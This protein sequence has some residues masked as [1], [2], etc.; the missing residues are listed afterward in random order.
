[1]VKGYDL[2][3]ESMMERKETVNYD[4]IKRASKPVHLRRKALGVLSQYVHR[5]TSLDAREKDG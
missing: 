2:K 1:M 3:I 5:I 4:L